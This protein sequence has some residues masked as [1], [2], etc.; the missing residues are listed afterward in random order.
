MIFV[1][2]L[3]KLRSISWKWYGAMLMHNL[4]KC[5]KMKNVGKH[6]SVCG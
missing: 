3:E 2:V 6:V 4:K 5:M 1:D